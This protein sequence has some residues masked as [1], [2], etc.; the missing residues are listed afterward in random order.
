[1]DTW[2]CSK[3][4]SDGCAIDARFS[5]RHSLSSQRDLANYNRAVDRRE[6]PKRTTLQECCR[7]YLFSELGRELGQDRLSRRGA[8]AVVH[9][10]AFLA[11]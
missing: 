3:A 6:R 5:Q 2:T 8:R 10:Q 7:W 1:V 4:I 11:G 9:G